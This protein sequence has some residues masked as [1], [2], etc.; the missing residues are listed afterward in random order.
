[1][2]YFILYPTLASRSKAPADQQDASPSDGSPSDSGA[3]Q[4]RGRL[5][6][7]YCYYY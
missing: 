7:Y 6:H 5:A 3:N 2:L 4:R 1:M